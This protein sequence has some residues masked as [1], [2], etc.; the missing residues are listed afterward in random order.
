MEE[1]KEVKRDENKEIR[2]A[3]ITSFELK[4]EKFIKTNKEIEK[5]RK[6][7]GLSGD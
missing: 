2:A 1:S 5:L 3:I 7:L 4:E 6:K